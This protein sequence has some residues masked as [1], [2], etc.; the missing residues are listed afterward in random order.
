MES[1]GGVKAVMDGSA[2]HP[3]S[4]V[5]VSTHRCPGRHEVCDELSTWSTLLL[6][7]GCSAVPCGDKGGLGCWKGT[8]GCCNTVFC[9]PHRRAPLSDEESKTNSSQHLGSQ[10]F[11]V[12]S[13][14]SKVSSSCACL[15]QRRPFL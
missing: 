9:S 12:S 1:S 13:S 7:V 10:E 6:P 5:A 11:C 15:G 3:R 14:L 4:P 8:L 2:S